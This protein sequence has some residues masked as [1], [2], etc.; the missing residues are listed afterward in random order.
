[1]KNRDDPESFA[2]PTGY[3]LMHANEYSNK[4]TR[5]IMTRNQIALELVRLSSVVGAGLTTYQAH[6]KWVPAVS[7][8]IAALLAYLV[9][10]KGQ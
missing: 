2:P 3:D 10:A 6:A 4:R 1:M 8:G 9:P 7:S 5:I